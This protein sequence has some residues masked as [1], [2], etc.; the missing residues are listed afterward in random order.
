MSHAG[1]MRLTP[2]LHVKATIPPHTLPTFEVM[3]N[4]L[5]MTPT[6]RL[7]SSRGLKALKIQRCVWI[8]LSS[9]SGKKVA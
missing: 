7:G 2:I 5:G 4:A 1:S 9:F 8:F 6:K 3:S